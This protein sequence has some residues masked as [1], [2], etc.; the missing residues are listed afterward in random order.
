MTKYCLEFKSQEEFKP[1]DYNSYGRYGFWKDLFGIIFPLLAF[2][3]LVFLAES[4]VVIIICSCLWFFIA[5]D[6]L[7]QTVARD[8]AVF[9]IKNK[10]HNIS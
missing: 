2:L 8:D 3:S 10:I 6:D 1:I 9:D 5:L 7:D 4:N